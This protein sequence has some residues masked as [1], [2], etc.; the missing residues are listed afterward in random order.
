MTAHNAGRTV[1]DNRYLVFFEPAAKL[2]YEAIDISL[3][4]NLIMLG[5]Y[6]RVFFLP[7]AAAFEP[8]FTIK[9]L[10]VKLSV[11]LLKKILCNPPRPSY[12]H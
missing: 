10:F 5:Q 9:E 1:A 3:L 11:K 6:N 4:L 12:L 2:L 8:A 7:A